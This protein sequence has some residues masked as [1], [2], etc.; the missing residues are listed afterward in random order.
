M[1]KK[2]RQRKFFRPNKK[3]SGN[4][5]NNLNQ[6]NAWLQLPRTRRN[7]QGTVQSLAKK[8]TASALERDG[9]DKEQAERLTQ[10]GQGGHSLRRAVAPAGP[11]PIGQ[12]GTPLCSAAVASAVALRRAHSSFAPPTST[13]LARTEVNWIG[14]PS[15][16]HQCLY[17]TSGPCLTLFVCLPRS[18]PPPAL[19]SS[20]NN[21]LS[22][23]AATPALLRSNQPIPANP[24]WAP[25]LLRI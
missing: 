24:P 14:F 5:Q 12:A 1:L 9:E 13:N 4:R 3:E 6:R 11:D 23:L 22:T 7:P 21:S 19:L 10:R 8:E 15:L 25:S 16:P 20:P 18:L 2:R 17:S